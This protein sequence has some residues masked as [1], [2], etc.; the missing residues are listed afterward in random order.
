MA[1]IL[2]RIAH[3]AFVLSLVAFAVF[4]VMTIVQFLQGNVEGALNS[5]YSVIASILG[6]VLVAS[7]FPNKMD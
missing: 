6:M 1:L 7:S 3:T 5:F 2:S 4:A